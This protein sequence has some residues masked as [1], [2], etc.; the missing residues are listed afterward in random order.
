MNDKLIPYAEVLFSLVLGAN[1]KPKGRGPEFL[2]Q[3][4]FHADKSPSFSANVERGLWKC[5][6][7]C[8]GGDLVDLVARHWRIDPK[9][10]FPKLVEQIEAATGASL[11][12]KPKGKPPSRLT[13]PQPNREEGDND[14]WGDPRGWA[15]LVADAAKRPPPAEFLAARGISPEVAAAAKL[16]TFT[17]QNTPKSKWVPDGSA[18][19]LVI[20]V[21]AGNHVLGFELRPE[22]GFPK[23]NGEK[24]KSKSTGKNFYRAP[25]P[26]G[27]YGRWVY[28]CE[29]LL[30]ALSAASAGVRACSPMPGAT[31]WED[32]WGELLWDRWVCVAY[33]DDDT[34][35]AMGAKVGQAI[36]PYACAVRV[37]NWHE[38]RHAGDGR[39]KNWPGNDVG[40]LLKALPEDRRREALNTLAETAVFNPRDI[41]TTLADERRT[42]LARALAELGEW[43]VDHGVRVLRGRYH[44]EEYKRGRNY[45]SEPDAGPHMVADGTSEDVPTL[46]LS[47]QLTD[48]T[49]R[50]TENV[51]TD[52]GTVLRRLAAR[53]P[54]M[55]SPI[56]WDN[57][58]AKDLSNPVM[59]K[60]M[61]LSKGPFVVDDGVCN[62]PRWNRILVRELKRLPQPDV[63][64]Y[65]VWSR[66]DLGNKGDYRPAPME[67]PWVF[68]DC[69]FDGGRWIPIPESR[70][71]DTSQGRIALRPLNERMP[72]MLPQP[73]KVKASPD[74]CF[75]RVASMWNGQ[76]DAPFRLSCGWIAALAFLPEIP[77]L[78]HGF[79]ILYF[80]GQAKSGK[81]FLLN[82]LRAMWGLKLEDPPLFPKK[83]APFKQALGELSNLPVAFDEAANALLE[84][85]VVDAINV[86]F[87]RGSF[88]QGSVQKRTE[89]IRVRAALALAGQYLSTRNDAVLSRMVTVIFHN[90]L[91]SMDSRHHRWCEREIDWACVGRFL[92][93]NAASLWERF[94]AAFQ[95]L[96]ADLVSHIPGVGERTRDGVALCGAG[97]CVVTG[98]DP[99]TMTE[100]CIRYAR[101]ITATTT[102]AGPVET[103][104]GWVAEEI[105]AGRDHWKV[106]RGAADAPRVWNDTEVELDTGRRARVFRLWA[107]EAF[108]LYE[109]DM[110]TRGGTPVPKDQVR[111]LIALR[112]DWHF[113]TFERAARLPGHAIPQKC[114]ILR[115]EVLPESLRTAVARVLGEADEADENG[116]TGALE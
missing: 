79:P 34:G 67:G 42:A 36:F 99:V 70:R 109:R 48:F 75:R 114:W 9:S 57:A 106:S 12:S 95:L 105:A 64:L 10:D 92:I 47:P 71:V 4:P 96:R 43:P 54:C 93:E 59:A 37:V 20:P 89:L 88:I 21:L 33:D 41:L 22:N 69:V 101:S 50:I 17:W 65:D 62:G 52:D 56:E 60:G 32:S 15:A 39:F 107:H 28:L 45:T 82:R 44:V 13:Y 66:M 86:V 5:H 115:R 94:Q 3:C 78:A 102:E 8:G 103:F 40:D 51:R 25:T 111:E 63:R 31:S 2:C 49:F 46:R 74:E 6:S 16:G 61:F 73:G 58:S 24:I 97:W 110:A 116:D 30:D 108:R 55:K 1:W 38:L 76:D 80:G 26:K 29:G 90:R 113:G 35:M 7:G 68:G 100:P 19:T 85:D 11:D 23:A 98:D 77:T 84:K 53:G 104:L 14:Y 91:R 72:L 27:D 83:Q 18:W 81:N 112:D 87:N